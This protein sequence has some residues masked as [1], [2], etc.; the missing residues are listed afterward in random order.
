MA[1]RG[2]DSR[3][4][5]VARR[6]GDFLVERLLVRALGLKLEEDT[7]LLER[8]FIDSTGV[9]EL[10]SFLEQEFGITV[11]DEEITPGNLNS[12]RQIAQYV[13]Q[14]SKVKSQK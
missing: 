9:L 13:S 4:A 8:R 10:V 5:E 2:P 12:V 6:V 1:A 11:A 14:K 7:P 3:Y